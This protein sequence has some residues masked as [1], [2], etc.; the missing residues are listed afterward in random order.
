LF[1]FFSILTNVLKLLFAVNINS[2][3]ISKAF[4]DEFTRSFLQSVDETSPGYYPFLSG[5]GAYEMEFPAQGIIG[6]R[7]YSIRDNSY[8]QL[9][10]GFGDDQT[11][12]NSTIQ[13][14]YFAAMISGSE[15]INM[16]SVAAR[17]GRDLEFEEIK[18][19]EQ[20]LFIAP[21]QI[22]LISQTNYKSQG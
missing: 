5:T 12:I 22:A 15:E 13:I 14:N 2:S 3:A 11:G 20:T 7:G 4:Q 10:I 21:Y 17:A 18:T 9:A 6:K 16:E 1:S 8:E 19:A